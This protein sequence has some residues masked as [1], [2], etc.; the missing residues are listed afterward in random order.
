MTTEEVSCFRFCGTISSVAA[1]RRTRGYPH[2]I[3]ETRLV[4]DRKAFLFFRPPSQRGTRLGEP[5]FKYGFN[6]S[7]Q[8]SISAISSLVNFTSET[9]GD[10][11]M[12]PLGP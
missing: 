7:K 4:T 3:A 9:M 10:V 2:V 12:T 1:D 6:P 11:G 8:Y 5:C